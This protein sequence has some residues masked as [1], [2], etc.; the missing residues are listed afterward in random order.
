[1][2]NNTILT[3]IIPDKRRLS[4][5]KMSLMNAESKYFNWIKK[6]IKRFF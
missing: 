6:L 3:I 2:Q 1:M 5:G 4:G